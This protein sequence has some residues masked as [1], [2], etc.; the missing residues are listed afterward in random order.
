MDWQ[1]FWILLLL[2]VH[3]FFMAAEYALINV[4]VS[5]IEVGA[6]MGSK[7]LGITKN[8]AKNIDKYL[9]V[10]QLGVTLSTIGI[11]WIG[12]TVV[13]NLVAPNPGLW[14]FFVAFLLLAFI[15]VLFAAMLPKYI[16]LHRP[17][18]T[19]MAF[20]VPLHAFYLLTIPLVWVFNVINSLLLRLF[21]LET[22]W[23]N[24]HH[25]S[26]ELQY[27]LEQG[28]E[29]GALEMKEYELIRKV[30]DFSE[31]MAKS[32]MVPRNKISALEMDSTMDE[33]LDKINNEGYSRIP[34]Y[35]E[36]I[37]QIVGIIHTKDVFPLINGHADFDIKTIIRK[38][39]FI[40]ETKKIND[41]M[42]ELQQRRIQIAIVLD[43]FGGT[44]GIVTLEDIMEELVG[45][46]QDEYDEETPVVEKISATEYM[47]DAS[48]N[49]HDANLFLPVPL[50]ESSDYD[51]IS[52]L[53]GDLFDKI[54]DVGEHKTL[55]G[56]NVII[57]KKT[58]QN[59][60]FVKLELLEHAV[61]SSD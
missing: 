39:Y 28:R 55:N 52:G 37:D 35:D 9:V 20:A 17:V 6:K 29:S 49:V 19:I 33:L 36:E 7:V 15:H 30:F 32:I 25:S 46:I 45:E 59:I 14:A 24:G 2:V 8:I 50:P 11:G 40:P 41:L 5:Q 38:P 16:A 43:E 27:L 61:S 21:G 31:R 54:P 26:E 10:T 60:D 23:R 58:Q 3:G 18:V 34:I 56:Y 1:L 44:A 57:M 53:V 51:T 47:V 42:A 22:K 48:A 4:R 13:Q 12:Y